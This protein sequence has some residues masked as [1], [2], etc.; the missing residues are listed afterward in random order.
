MSRNTLLKPRS[1]GVFPVLNARSQVV[2]TVSPLQSRTWSTLTLR[3]TTLTVWLTPLTFLLEHTIFSDPVS[4]LPSLYRCMFHSANI[5]HIL[6]ITTTLLLVGVPSLGVSMVTAWLLWYLGRGRSLRKQGVMTLSLSTMFLVSYLPNALYI[7]SMLLLGDFHRD[8]LVKFHGFTV[9][10]Q[11]VNVMGNPIV[12]FL[13]SRS[14]NEFVKNRVL[15]F[16]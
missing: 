6:E 15:G 2:S 11:F 10:I 16:L 4:F 13:S 14:F 12:Y 9:Y 8:H 1:T 7:V 5:P 3:L